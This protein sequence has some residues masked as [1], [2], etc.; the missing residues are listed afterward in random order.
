MKRIDRIQG[1]TEPR[2]IGPFQCKKRVDDDVF[3][4]FDKNGVFYTTAPIQD[5]KK[6][7]IVDQDQLIDL[8]TILENDIVIESDQLN[9][10]S[11][12]VESEE[13]IL[14]EQ[15]ASITTNTQIFESSRNKRYSEAE[16]LPGKRKIFKKVPLNL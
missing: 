10:N 9:N 4:L 2:Y 3:E 12:E 7:K 15:Q 1:K 6:V 14:N 8:K 13:Q 16:I 11:P 5:L